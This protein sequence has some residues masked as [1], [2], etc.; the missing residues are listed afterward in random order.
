MNLPTNRPE[1]KKHPRIPSKGEVPDTPTPTP[2]TP[3][4]PPT[5]VAT[6]DYAAGLGSEYEP[7]VIRVAHILMQVDLVHIITLLLLCRALRME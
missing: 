6:P 4:A 7:M 5:Y 3:A 1:G 2:T